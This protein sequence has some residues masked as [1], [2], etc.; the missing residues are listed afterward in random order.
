MRV[1]PALGV[2]PRELANA[3]GVVVGSRSCDRC[4]RGGEPEEQ[5]ERDQRPNL[6]R[7]SHVLSLRS[8]GHGAPTLGCGSLDPADQRLASW[9]GRFIGELPQRTASG[10]HFV[11]GGPPSATNAASSV[12]F[13]APTFISTFDT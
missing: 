11:G 12:R 13:L 6:L 7:T 10:D 3:R 5:R 4:R 2:V 9:S 1:A 8:V